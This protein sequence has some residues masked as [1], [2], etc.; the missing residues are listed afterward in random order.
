MSATP[1]AKDKEVI[2]KENAPNQ[3]RILATATDNLNLED[4]R[5]RGGACDAFVLGCVS[6]HASMPS[7]ARAI[8]EGTLTINIT[9][10][11]VRNA[12]MFG[13]LQS[14]KTPLI[15]DGSPGQWPSCR[16]GRQKA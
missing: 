6:S 13:Q 10:T 2:D 4:D 3:T 9:K 11:R 12:N 15:Q 16:N 8:G 14:F 1:M 7:D 5:T